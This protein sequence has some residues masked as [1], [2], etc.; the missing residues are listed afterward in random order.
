MV[1]PADAVRAAFAYIVFGGS[2]RMMHQLNTT[3]CSGS[4]EIYEIVKAELLE[5]LAD[6]EYANHPLIPLASDVIADQIATTTIEGGYSNEAQVKAVHHSLFLH[7]YIA[8]L[9]AVHGRGTVSI[10]FASTFMGILAGVLM[11]KAQLSVLTQLQHIL[12][13]GGMGVLFEAQVHKTLYEKFKNGDGELRLVR[14]FRSGKGGHDDYCAAEGVHPNS[15]G[16]PT[17]ETQ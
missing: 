14:M 11:E 9:D 8:R 5:F 3:P 17:T 16:H 12:T 4:E 10:G 13:N 1:G 15:G 2:A 7:T 6:S